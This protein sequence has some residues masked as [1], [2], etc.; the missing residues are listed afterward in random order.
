MNCLVP[1]AAAFGSLISA[2]SG[3]AV[4]KLCCDPSTYQAARDGMSQAN[5]LYDDGTREGIMRAMVAE[6]PFKIKLL[7]CLCRPYTPDAPV[8]PGHVTA[9]KKAGNAAAKLAGTSQVVND[10]I[11]IS[12]AKAFVAAEEAAKKLAQKTNTNVTTTAAAEESLLSS[13]SRVVKAIDTRTVVTVG[14]GIAVVALTTYTIYQLCCG[15][16]KKAE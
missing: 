6:E 5:K 1:A 2:A 4:T 7:K 8:G 3:V 14:A 16:K 13:L 10:A 15:G 11:H 12:E 9:L